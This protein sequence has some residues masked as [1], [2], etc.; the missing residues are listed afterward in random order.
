MEVKY[1][2]QYFTLSNF[3]S[4]FKKYRISNIIISA[5]KKYPVK[6][7]QTYLCN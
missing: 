4:V 2:L 7:S 6:L 1:N 5:K 3:I